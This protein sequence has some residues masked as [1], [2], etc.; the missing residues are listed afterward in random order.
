MNVIKEALRK[1]E[2]FHI[3]YTDRAGIF[4]KDSTNHFDAV[5]REDDKGRLW[6]NNREVLE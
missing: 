3:L 4:G 5:K 6:K 1:H 2:I